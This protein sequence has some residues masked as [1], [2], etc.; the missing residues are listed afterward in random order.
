MNSHQY[1]VGMDMWFDVGT[2]TPRHYHCESL[3]DLET[4]PRDGLQAWVVHFHERPYRANI[5]GD[6]QFAAPHP[7]GGLIISGVGNG[8]MTYPEMQRAQDDV[9]ARY[10]GAICFFTRNTTHWIHR[11]AKDA[12]EKMRM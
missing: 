8:T 10:P 11:Q 9:R 2:D 7:A 3:D 1:V 6:V 4:L 12:A 5:T